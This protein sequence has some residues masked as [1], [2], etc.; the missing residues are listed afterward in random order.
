MKELS[1]K[2]DLGYHKA[3]T[4]YLAG[5][6]DPDYKRHMNRWHAQMEAI[7]SDQSHPEN[8]AKLRATLKQEYCS[9]TI[10]DWGKA[11]IAKLLEK[12]RDRLE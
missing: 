5:E 1:A 10:P 4:A 9:G 7:L 3:A 12:T 6:G 8:A 11:Q 2:S